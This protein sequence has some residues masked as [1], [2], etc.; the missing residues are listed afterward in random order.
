LSRKKYV[1][2]NYEIRVFFNSHFSELSGDYLAVKNLKK[3]RFLRERLEKEKELIFT[4]DGQPFTLIIGIPPENVERSLAEIRRAKFSS[5][6]MGGR[7]KA[8]SSPP[9][10][11][12]R[13]IPW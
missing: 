9:S 5:A 2:I 4:K 10:L 7:K 11:E 12:D 8:V 13:D 1:D 3:T 6:V